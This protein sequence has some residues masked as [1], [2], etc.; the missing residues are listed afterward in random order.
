MPA[1]DWSAFALLLIDAQEDFWTDEVAATA[2]RF[3]EHVAE[4]LATCRSEGMDV[5]HAH[6]LFQADRSDWMPRYRLGRALPCIAGTGGERVLE[7]ASPIDGEPVFHKQTYDAML[8]PELRSWL[9]QNNK[10]FLLVAGLVT[11]TCVFLTAASAA[12]QG[13]LVAVVDDAAADTADGHDATLERYD[14]VFER[15]GSRR[16]IDQHGDWRKQLSELEL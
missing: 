2:P 7:E 16:I 15:V 1:R 4:L 6:A 12:Q 9:E 11:S 10:R 3:R 14:F 5:V 13:Y 8:V